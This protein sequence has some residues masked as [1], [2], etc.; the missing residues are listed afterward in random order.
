MLQTR[1][2]PQFT[3]FCVKSKPITYWYTIEYIT[4]VKKVKL[5]IDSNKNI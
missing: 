3:E 5:K 4:N 1:N 2:R